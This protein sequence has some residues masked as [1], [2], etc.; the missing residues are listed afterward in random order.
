MLQSKQLFILGVLGV[1]VSIQQVQAEETIQLASTEYPPYT[2]AALPNGGVITA[3]ASEAFK[4]GGYTAKVS[5]LPWARALKD[6]ED[7][8]VEGIVGIWH[9]KDREKSFVFS[10]PLP[11]NQIGIYK[12]SDSPI[13]Y[14]NLSDLKPYT[15]GTGRGYSNPAAFEAA[16]LRTAEALDDETNMRKLGSSRIDLVLIDK[17]VAQYLIDTKLTEFKGKLAWIEPAI[18]KVP[19]YVA[20]SK[21]STNNDKKVAAFNQGLA[22]MEKDG[23]LAKMVS[24]AGI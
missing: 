8:N 21:K 20:F 9:N 16:K 23:T 11:S 5:F 24:Q 15:I 7:G 2:G 10:A 19:L 3:I 4:R 12:R 13:S 1:C 17:G 14:K 6:G 22:S 18:E